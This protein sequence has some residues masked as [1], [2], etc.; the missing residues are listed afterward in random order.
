M[1]IMRSAAPTYEGDELK[2]D[3]PKMPILGEP[4]KESIRTMSYPG[5]EELE[6]CS[7]G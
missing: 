6:V 1:W 5:R 2:V 7:S 3:L 4:M